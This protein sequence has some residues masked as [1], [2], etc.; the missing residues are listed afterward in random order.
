[1][2]SRQNPDFVDVIIEME[3]RI[4]RLEFWV[5]VVRALAVVAFVIANALNMGWLPR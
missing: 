5:G 2:G 4:R 1:M 3:A